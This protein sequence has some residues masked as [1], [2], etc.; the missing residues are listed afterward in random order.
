M[1]YIF[2]LTSRTRFVAEFSD[3]NPEKMDGSGRS[4]VGIEWF[5]EFG[6]LDFI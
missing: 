6:L 3:E 4:Q 1:V 2:K 5:L